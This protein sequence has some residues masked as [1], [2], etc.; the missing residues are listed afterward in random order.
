M[1]SA[2]D[3]KVIDVNKN[4]D[5]HVQTVKLHAGDNKFNENGLKYL[6]RSIHRIQLL[7]KKMR[8]D[9]PMEKQKTNIMKMMNHLEGSHVLMVES[10]EVE[11]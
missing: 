7:L 3:A 1:E 9:S 2:A 6:V 8:F 5:G 10:C 11:R 4:N